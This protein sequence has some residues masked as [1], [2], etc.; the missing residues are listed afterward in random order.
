MDRLYGYSDPRVKY[1]KRSM[2]YLEVPAGGMDTYNDADV[3]QE[4]VTL[5]RENE[6]LRSS[7]S[8]LEPLKD[9]DWHGKWRIQKCLN[10]LSN[11]ELDNG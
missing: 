7:I 11:K 5:M 8:N 3:T 2:H 4:I 10:A 6:R 9:E 1:I